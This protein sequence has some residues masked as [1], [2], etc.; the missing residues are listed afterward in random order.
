[1]KTAI[2]IVRA[3]A[4]LALMLTVV[5]GGAWGLMTVGLLD[6]IW[7]TSWSE[8]LTRP[9]DGAL[10]LGI[11]TIVGWIAWS[12]ATLSL[13]SEALAAA[14][15]QRCRL[16]FPGSEVLAPVST[17]LVAA[18]LGLIAS[19]PV[20]AAPHQIAPAVPV[21]AADRKSTRLNSSH[22]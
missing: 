8:I 16:R 13:V 14:T 20:G 4:A 18:V 3:L 12:T 17:V 6:T 9:D 1:M 21:A 15:R 10:L 5:I 11:I 7:T 22:T 19:Q 2:R